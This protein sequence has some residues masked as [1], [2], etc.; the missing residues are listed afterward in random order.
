M[1][2]CL[3]MLL[4]GGLRIAI[5]LTGPASSADAGAGGHERR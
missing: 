2:I 1:K 5:L 4:I 3:L